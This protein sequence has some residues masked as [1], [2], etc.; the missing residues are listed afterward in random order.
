[1]YRAS[2]IVYCPDQLIHNIYYYYY[3]YYYYYLAGST[4]FSLLPAPVWQLFYLLPPVTS[5]IPIFFHQSLFSHHSF[6]PFRPGEFRST[7]FSSSRLT[8]FHNF[9]WQFYIWVSVHHK[10]IIYN[11]PTRCNSGSIVFINNYRYALHVSDA[12]CAHHQEHY[13]L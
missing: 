11:K 8:P 1:M 3:Y 12:L 7:S 6:N 9:F 10:S 4:L 5:V 2:S 13:K